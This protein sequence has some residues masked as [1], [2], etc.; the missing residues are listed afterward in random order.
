[1][2]TIHRH[3]VRTGKQGSRSFS[4]KNESIRLLS[5]KDADG[6]EI[7][8]VAGIV[9]T[10][11]LGLG[12]GRGV[13][14]FDRLIQIPPEAADGDELFLLAN[15]DSQYHTHY[16]LALHPEDPGTVIK[17]YRLRGDHLE[18]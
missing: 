11:D 7:D 1:M 16:T 18:E 17:A 6:G 15:H 4:I 9:R 13:Y 12:Y 8:Y 10:R 14:T 3:Q 2:I 5:R